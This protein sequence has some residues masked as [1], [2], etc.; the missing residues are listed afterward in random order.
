MADKEDI[1]GILLR[2][3][4]QSPAG[5]AI[6]FHV[7]FTTPEFLLQTY[8]TDWI[9]LYSERGYV[10]QDPTVSWGFNNEGSIRWSE[11]ADQDSVGI[12]EECRKFD[13][14]FGVSVAI[15]QGGSRSFASF[16][17]SDRDFTDAECA[18]LHDQLA[19]LHEMTLSDGSMD[20]D[21]RQDLHDL[22]VQMTHPDWRKG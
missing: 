2:L 18:D 3:E 16:T 7:K 22:S 6:A 4:E 8:P 1:R 11:L 19:T 21:L 15:E 13:M 14:N 10:M 9:D 20:A 5:F 17:R 12:F